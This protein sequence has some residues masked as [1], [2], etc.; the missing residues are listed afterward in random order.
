MAD[1][2]RL[3]HGL[4]PVVWSFALGSTLGA[5]LLALV[6]YRVSLTMIVAHRRRTSHQ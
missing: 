2:R 3:A 4:A 6:A 1:V 5:A